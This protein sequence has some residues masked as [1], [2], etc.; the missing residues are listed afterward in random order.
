MALALPWLE[1]MGLPGR[2][3]AHAAAFPKRFIVFFSPDGTIRDEWVPTGTE[4]ALICQAS[5]PTGVDATK[6]DEPA[7][8]DTNTTAW[9]VPFAVSSALTGP[10]GLLC[11][12]DRPPSCVARSSGRRSHSRHAHLPEADCTRSRQ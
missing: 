4:S 5:W 10:A 1:A 7:A 6:N 2:N 8:P 9:A 3:V 11:C 12:Q